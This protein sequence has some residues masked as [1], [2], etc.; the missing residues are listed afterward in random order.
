MSQKVDGNTRT[1]VAGETI[2][3]GLLVRLSAAETVSIAGLAQ[4]PIAVA[5][6]RVPA[7]EQGAFDLLSKAGTVQCKAGGAFS[8]GAV[9]YGRAA[10]LVDDISTSSA[11]KIGVALE[12][13][14]AANDIIEVLPG[15]V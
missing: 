3:R 13:A 4:T 12:A 10:G 14:T 7:G 8:A 9:V 6:R 5:T 1:F 2:E 15:G 11:V